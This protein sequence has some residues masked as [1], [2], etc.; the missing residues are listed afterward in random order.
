MEADERAAPCVR[1]ANVAL[2]TC[3]HAPIMEVAPVAPL[4]DVAPLDDPEAS[5]RTWS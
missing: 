3:L 5:V 1:S 2:R 4:P